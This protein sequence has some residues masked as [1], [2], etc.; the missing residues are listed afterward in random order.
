MTKHA[1]S[2]K[3]EKQLLHLVFGGELETLDGVDLPRPSKLDIVGIYPT[4][5]APSP[6]GRP[7]RNRPWTMRICAISS[8]ISTSCSIPTTTSCKDAEALALPKFAGFEKNKRRHRPDSRQAPRF[9][10]SAPPGAKRG[11]A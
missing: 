11:S 2:A 7:K 9:R 5:T 3:N 10:L 1:T 8:C 6:P 4:M